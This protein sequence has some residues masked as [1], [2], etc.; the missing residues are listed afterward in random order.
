MTG[1]KLLQ[2]LERNHLLIP[3]PLQTLLH[4]AASYGYDDMVEH[5]VRLGIHVDVID[6]R[7]HKRERERE[8]ERDFESENCRES[9]S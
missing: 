9:L 3:F 7:F 5:F 6:V 2:L 4:T 8:R 1:C